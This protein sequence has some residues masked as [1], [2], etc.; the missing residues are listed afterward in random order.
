MNWRKDP[1]KFLKFLSRKL[2]VKKKRNQ[3]K[4]TIKGN[5]REEKVQRRLRN[6]TVKERRMKSMEHQLDKISC[7]EIDAPVIGVIKGRLSDVVVVKLRDGVC[8]FTSTV[9]RAVR[10]RERKKHSV[11]SKNPGRARNSSLIH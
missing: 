7:P 5:I 4:G 11:F 8:K 3:K 10:V 6:E 9:N 2:R 1:N